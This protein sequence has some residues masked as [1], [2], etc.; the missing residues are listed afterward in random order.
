[1]KKLLSL[2]PNLVSYFHDIEGKDEQEWFCASDPVGK[3]VGSGGGTSWLLKESWKSEGEVSSFDKWLSDDK[4]V[5]MHAGG[6]SRRLPSYASVGKILTPI[7]VFRWE[8]GQRLDQNLLDLQL[9]L[10]EKILSKAPAGLNTLI[11]SGDVYIRAEGAIDALPN[12]DVVCYGLWADP[13]QATNHGVFVCDRNNPDDLQYML[14]KPS[15]QVLQDLAGEH[16]YLM[17]IGIWILSDRAVE[18]LMQKSGYTIDKS[19]KLIVPDD[20]GFYD[21]YSDFGLSLGSKAVCADKEVNAL[22]VAI[23]PLPKGEFYHYGTSKEL[24]SSTLSIQNRIVDQRSIL[25]KDSKPHPSMFI[26]NAEVNIKLNSHQRNLWIENSFIGDGCHI[27][28]EHILTGI[29]E[30]N[31]KLDLHS[32]ICLDFMP[33]NEDEYCIRPYG[34]YDAFRGAVGSEDT[35][36]M[37]VSFSE[38]IRERTIEFSQLDFSADEDIQSARLFPV[39][40]LS[41]ITEGFVQW[42]VQPVK[43]EH[44]L[45]LWRSSERL[46]ADMLSDRA[47]LKRLYSQRNHFRNRNITQLHKNYRKSVFHQ[48]DLNHEARRVALNGI[49]LSEDLII[50]DDRFTQMHEQ[51]FRAKVKQYQ[52]KDYSKEEQSAFRILQDSIIEPLRNEKLHPHLSVFHDQIVWGRSP[53]RIDLA[54]GWT[55]TPPNCLINGGAVVNMAVE[56]N[57]QPPLQVYIKPAKEYKIILRS[58]DIGTREDINTYDELS[59]YNQV[60]S[61]FSIPKAA[62]VLAGFHPSYSAEYYA[63]LEM[64]LQSFGSGIEISTLA[65][66]P[67]GSGLGTSSILAATVLGALSD[68]CGHSWSHNE[69]S[70]RTLVLEQLLTTGGGWQ[71]Q[72]GGVLPGIKLLESN[73]GFNQTLEVKWTSD[74]LFTQPEYKA[75]ML[76]YYTGI[77]RTAKDILSEIV[78]GMFLNDS[79]NTFLVKEMK[80]HAFDTFNVLQRNDFGGLCTSVKRTWEQNKML[81]RGTNP[82]AV[83]QLIKSFE[84]F[85]SAYKLPGAGGGGYMYIIAKD[86]DAAGRIRNLLNSNP[87]NNRARFVDMNLSQSGFQV[88]RS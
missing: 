7:P 72:Y 61:A 56:L 58:I 6:Q 54:G 62:L 47:N 49:Q 84:D 8:R 23:L 36:W 30:N 32:G 48:V 42:M 5:V 27:E 88:T 53:V 87:P 55:D 67:K 60:G 1:M 64:Q 59:C 11:A 52:N 38:W 4:R 24:I 46:S 19:G 28:S 34:Y 35:Q 37:G 70:H 74:F 3:R 71:D 33:V 15:Q 66:I 41:D 77:T 73:K 10:Y 85:A 79:A 75:C 40:K 43:D 57:G 26:Q 65:A 83:Q 76:L 9:P 45:Q 12:A 29:P 50:C 18:V 14:Q 31:W 51:M 69:I 39:M 21:L 68:F 25:H 78:K 63:S 22:S 13:S 86:P 20:P 81:D 17:D 16:L 80:Q 2:P 82:P 44:Y